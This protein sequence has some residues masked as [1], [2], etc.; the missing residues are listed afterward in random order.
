MY[1]MQKGGRTVET[2]C[3]EAWIKA[4]FKVL[5]APTM[6]KREPKEAAVSDNVEKPK[7]KYVRRAVKD[8]G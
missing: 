5:S 2:S 8:N 7:R 6:D 1:I 4:G 3:K